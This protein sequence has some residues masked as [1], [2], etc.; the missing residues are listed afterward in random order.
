MILPGDRGRMFKNS[1]KKGSGVSSLSANGRVEVC[2]DVVSWSI[3][4]NRTHK[5]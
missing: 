3:E 5:G 1:L 4:N 2:R